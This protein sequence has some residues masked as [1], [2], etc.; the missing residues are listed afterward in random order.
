[1]EKSKLVTNSQPKSLKEILKEVLQEKKIIQA[2]K[3]YFD[4]KWIVNYELKIVRTRTEELVLELA[5]E[6]PQIQEA[7]KKVLQHESEVRFWIPS[8]GV[9]FSS[10]LVSHHN[11]ELIVKFPKFFAHQDRRKHLRLKVTD[12]PV[13]VSIPMVWPGSKS[14]SYKE[15]P[16]FDLSAG[17]FSFIATKDEADGFKNGLQIPRIMLTIDGKSVMT[18]AKVITIVTIEPTKDNGLYYAS[19]KICF[20]FEQISIEDQQFIDSYVMDAI[21]RSSEHIA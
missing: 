15:K 16:P 7:A 18:E 2:W 17:G 13:M 9:L 5:Q 6:S 1:M 3:I 10:K 20:T 19:S 12:Q 4:K 8:M 11:S 21:L 14:A